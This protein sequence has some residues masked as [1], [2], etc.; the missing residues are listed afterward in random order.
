MNSGANIMAKPTSFSS[1]MA[2]EGRVLIVGN[3]KN[4]IVGFLN[5]QNDTFYV[6]DRIEG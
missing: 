3:V 5:R 1:R 4:G 6:L 2:E